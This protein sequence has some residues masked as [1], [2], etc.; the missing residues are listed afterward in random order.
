M[1]LRGCVTGSA[2]EVRWI[3]LDEDERNRLRELGIREGAVLHVV[4][5][6]AF[7]SK[8]VALGSD[9][10]AI[11]GRTCACIAVLPQGTGK[12]ANL[13]GSLDLRPDPASHKAAAQSVNS[14]SVV[15]EAAN[16][17]TKARPS[18][19]NAVRLNKPRWISNR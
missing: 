18:L 15:C 16:S 12:N 9:R 17:A 8:V 3:D 2:V 13:I 11:D 5:C 1:D 6:G 7:G 19:T 10:F 14:D 4:N